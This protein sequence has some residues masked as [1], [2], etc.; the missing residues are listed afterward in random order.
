MKEEAARVRLVELLQI[1]DA[2]AGTHHPAEQPDLTRDQGLVLALYANC[3]SML[4]GITFLL[5]EEHGQEATILMRTLL[6]D[7]TTVFYVFKNQ[8]TTG[9][10]TVRFEWGSLRQERLILEEAMKHAPDAET[11]A[12]LLEV[13]ALA[14]QTKKEAEELGMVLQPLPPMEQLFAQV[15]LPEG[16]YFFRYASHAVHTSRLALWSRMTELPDRRVTIDFGGTPGPVLTVGLFS[17]ELFLNVYRATARLL[18]W[19]TAGEIEAFVQE[20]QGAFLDLRREAGVTTKGFGQ[21]EP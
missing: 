14:K 18:A 3:R 11:K 20:H 7:A 10:M 19:S 15:D 21:P 5:R 6:Q 17:G 1:A 4:R 12:A 2:H 8:P 16:Y 9:E 13:E